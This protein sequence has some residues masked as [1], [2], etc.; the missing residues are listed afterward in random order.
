MNDWVLNNT[1]KKFLFKHISVG[2]IKV[3][4]LCHVYTFLPTVLEAVK[5]TMKR[6]VLHEN[7]VAL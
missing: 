6:I 4:P 5:V 7:L 1:D 3:E 2:Y